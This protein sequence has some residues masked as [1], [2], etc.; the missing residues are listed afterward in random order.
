MIDFTE[1]YIL[2]IDKPLAWTSTDV[3]RKATNL[4]KYKL[5]LKK[6]KVGHAG[7]LD[8][9]ATGLLIVCIGKAT[10]KV[11]E[12]QRGEKEYLADLRFGATTPSYDLEKEPDA[13]FPYE[14]ITEENLRSL[15]RE[16]TGEIEQRP[17]IFS[18]KSIAGKRAYDYARMGDVPEIAPVK[19]NIYETELLDYT[20]PT[21][22]IRVRCSKGTYIRSLADDL[23]K[24]A[25]SGAYL[26]ALRRTASGEYRVESAMTIKEMEM[27]F[28]LCKSKNPKTQTSE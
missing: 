5:G 19:V 14:H 21:A 3:V 16:F 22:R 1:G 26:S 2:P 20:A 8:P 24:A 6:I 28:E 9:L 18:A 17:P 12:I 10:K 11:E 23:G 7:T 27:F 15:L 13:F 4:L 25:G